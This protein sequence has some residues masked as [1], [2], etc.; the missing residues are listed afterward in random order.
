MMVSA[1]MTRVALLLSALLFVVVASATSLPDSLYIDSVAPGTGISED[2]SSEYVLSH[3]QEVS[4][5]ASDRNVWD[6]LQ[7]NTDSRVALLDLFFGESTSKG[8]NDNADVDQKDEDGQDSET[9]LRRSLDLLSPFRSSVSSTPFMTTRDLSAS[10]KNS[11]KAPKEVDFIGKCFLKADDLAKAT[12]NCSGH[13]NATQT[14]VGGRKC[15]RCKCQQTKGKGGNTIDWAGAAC[16]KQDISKPFVLLLT[17]TV[18]L[19]FVIL[20]SVYYLFYEGQKELPSVLAG[21]SIP[22]K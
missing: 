19:L 15:F 4:G 10:L 1:A 9:L 6:K 7:P 17:T 3:L 2:I 14:S 5:A 22:N 8:V 18:G 13:G 11:T 16:Q 20:G 12:L 21:I